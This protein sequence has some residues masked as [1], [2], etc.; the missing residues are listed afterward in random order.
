MVMLLSCLCGLCAFQNIIINVNIARKSGG[1][2]REKRN[3]HDVDIGVLF[4]WSM[5]TSKYG[6]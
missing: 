6:K 3:H 1:K 4:T 2:K 5:H